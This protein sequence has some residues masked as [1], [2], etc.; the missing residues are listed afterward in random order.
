M[1]ERRSVTPGY[2]SAMGIPV[3]AGR[4]VT[5]A[6]AAGQPL[7]VVINETLARQFFNS[8]N[9]IGKRIRVAPAESGPWR[10]VIGVV[11]DVRSRSLEAEPRPQ[12]YFPHAQGPW[13]S[14]TVVLLARGEPAALASTA[15]SELRALDPALPAAQLRTLRQVVSTATSARR[16][17]MALLVLFAG[18][19]LFLTMIGIYGVVSYLAG[20]QRREIGIRL[21]L[22]ANRG[23]V[24]RMILQQGMKP[25]CLGSLLGLAGSLAG[26]RLIASQLYGVSSSDPVTL[27]T[28]VTLLF[29]VALLACWLPARRAANVDPMV[30][31]RY[32]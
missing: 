17:N 18:T 4:V 27:A 9:P 23:H 11:S 13:A 1:A 2:F 26:S 21:A 12:I 24:R 19:A 29:S 6:D 25:V 7:V 15:R 22:G 32:A 10:T 28:I 20:R 5:A 3:R 31:L 14:M 30:A 8:D 16:F